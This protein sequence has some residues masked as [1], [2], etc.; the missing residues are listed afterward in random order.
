MAPVYYKRPFA[1]TASTERQLHYSSP[2]HYV[3][4]NT[5]CTNPYLCATVLCCFGQSNNDI[6]STK[7]FYTCSK[8]IQTKLV[9][10]GTGNILYFDL[11]SS[12]LE[13]C[14]LLL[15]VV[16]YVCLLDPTSPNS[17]FFPSLPWC[18][19]HTGMSM[20]AFP[21]LRAVFKPQALSSAPPNQWHCL[22]FKHSVAASFK[23][24]RY[25]PDSVNWQETLDSLWELC[26]L[27]Q[28]SRWT[29]ANATGSWNLDFWAYCIPSLE[30]SHF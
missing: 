15:S 23:L 6:A 27:P 5:C 20:C 24:F 30:S 25:T 13:N 17:H 7:T 2:H 11:C 8:C 14:L 16:L 19:Q 18:S 29:R 9:Q 1:P 21:F 28:R 26:R 3:T 4:Q 10:V 12:T 22:M